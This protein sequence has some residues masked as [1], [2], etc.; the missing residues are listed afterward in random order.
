ME[1]TRSFLDNLLAR[2]DWTSN[3]S[4]APEFITLLTTNE[5]PTRFQAGQLNASI[6]H[7]G[8]PILE[9][10]AEIDLLRHA[11]A[12]LESRML[13]LSKIRD[14][15]KGSLSS[16]RRLPAEIIVQIL[17]WTEEW[18]TSHD[19]HISG[20]DVSDLSDG[21]WYLGQVC[22]TWRRTIERHC[23]QLWSRLTINFPQDQEDS[24]IGEAIP[25]FKRNMGALL[26]LVLA[27][28]GRSHLDFSFRATSHSI[29]PPKYSEAHEKIMSRCFSLLLTH[30]TRWRSVELIIPAFLLSDIRF[31]HGRVDMLE[32]VYLTCGKYAEP[33]NI[34]AFEIAPNLETLHLTDMHPEAIISIPPDRLVTFLDARRETNTNITRQHLDAVASGSCLL[35]FL[36]HHHSHIPV[37]LSQF[38]IARNTS[39]QSLSA[40]LGNFLNS[41][42]VPSLNHMTVTSGCD[43]IQ[44]PKY[45][46]I[47]CPADSLLG[48]HNLIMRSRCSLTVLHLIDV[49]MMDD[50]ILYIIQLTPQLLIFTIEHQSYRLTL[51]T[52]NSEACMERL[53]REM[54]KTQSVGNYRN[55]DLVPSLQKLAV[56]VREVDGPV[57]FLDDNFV[58]MV[59]SRR[60]LRCLS[61]FV[62]LRVLVSGRFCHSHVPLLQ[63]DGLF[64][65]DALV[66]DDFRLKLRFHDVTDRIRD[67]NEGD[68]SDY[69]SDSDSD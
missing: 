16:V 54:T 49:P 48:L 59:C 20:F 52:G 27:R 25:V 32:D 64:K 33:G 65:L 22:S 60:R 23:P 69:G 7:L 10:Q 35:S 58:G 2:Y 50:R 26:K 24:A 56:T 38:P 47:I 18:R 11:A 34:N 17:G 21:P 51:P 46:G 61:A 28:S 40:S 55:H 53:F 12:S 42:D 5:V 15:Y 67:D 45:H 36:C 29:M 8:P 43:F 41:L 62:D 14:D 19:Y 39:L 13:R 6:Q 31:I 44:N 9:I 3:F 1:S 57:P 37:S 4:H 66:K 63:T 30:S 68:Y